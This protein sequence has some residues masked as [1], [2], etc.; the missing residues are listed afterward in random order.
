MDNRK[1]MHQRSK[2][3]LGSRLGRRVA[4]VLA[5]DVISLTIGTVGYVELAGTSTIDGFLNAAML[6]GGMGPVGD[7]HETA[8]KLF[9]SFYALYAGLFFIAVAGFLTTPLIHHMLL[10]FHVEDAE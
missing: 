2:A 6:L 10:T 3:R 7:I 9:A 1:A 4:I 8:G 5:A